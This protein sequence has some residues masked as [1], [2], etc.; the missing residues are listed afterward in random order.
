MRASIRAMQETA[1]IIHREQSIATVESEI[2]PVREI[3]R[4]Q[5][6]DELKEAERRYLPTS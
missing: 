6:A 5:N 1:A 2:V 4:L 3:F